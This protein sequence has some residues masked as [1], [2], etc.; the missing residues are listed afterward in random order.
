MNMSLARAH[1]VL[2]LWKLG[3]ENFPRKVI[4]MALYLTGDIASPA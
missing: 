1:E 4:D 2:T 3:A